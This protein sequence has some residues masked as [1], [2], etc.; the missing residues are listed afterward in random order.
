MKFLQSDDSNVK[1]QLAKKSGNDEANP[2][3]EA[4]DSIKPGVERSGT[5]R[6]CNE[7]RMLIGGPN[8]AGAILNLHPNTLRSQ[9]KRLGIQRGVTPFRERCPVHPFGSGN[10]LN[11]PQIISFLVCCL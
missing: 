8:G 3:C 11:P 9:M 4:G 10:S 2:A 1:R 7:P 6:R 5:P